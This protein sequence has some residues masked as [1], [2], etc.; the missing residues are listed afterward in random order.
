[1]DYENNFD[2]VLK[3]FKIIKP[4]FSETLSPL[5]EKGLNLGK[6]ILYLKLLQIN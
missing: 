5:S 1:M 4:S 2:K 6:Q 3:E